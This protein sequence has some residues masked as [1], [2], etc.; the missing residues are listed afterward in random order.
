MATRKKVWPKIKL[1]KAT[2]SEILA[3]YE[4]TPAEL[5]AAKAALAAVERKRNRN[6][7]A[8]VKGRTAPN[9]GRRLP[10]SNAVAK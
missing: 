10:K 1:E 9:K 6:A 4:F 7:V 2:A 5:R 3:S 8:A